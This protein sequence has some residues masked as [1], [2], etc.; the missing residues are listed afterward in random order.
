LVSRNGIVRKPGAT[1][2]YVDT[3]GKL[4]LTMADG[5]V[6]GWAASS[7]G[8]NVVATGSAAPMVG[9]SYTTAS[10]PTGPGQFTFESKME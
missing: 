2:V 5:K 7:R 1:V 3:G 9:K 6:T 8:T 4:A 10:K